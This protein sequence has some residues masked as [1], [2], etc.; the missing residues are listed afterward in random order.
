L[1][2]VVLEAFVLKWLK[3]VV[4]QNAFL[5][6]T[7]AA[8]RERSQL[9]QKQAAP[10]SAEE[11]AARLSKYATWQAKQDDWREALLA[12]KK[13]LRIFKSTLGQDHPL[14]ANTLSKIGIAYHHLNEP[15]YAYDSFEKALEIQESVL[16]PGDAEI[17]ITQENIRFVLVE[18]REN[19]EDES[20]SRD[21]DP[22]SDSED[23]SSVYQRE[24]NT[25]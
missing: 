2:E 8:F 4:P 24:G 23:D 13:A 5:K 12:W 9:K 7:L 22:A 19:T 25:I 17:K 10:T 1:P 21:D 6:G 20:S 15:F 14:V 16:P 11:F 3:M 18:S